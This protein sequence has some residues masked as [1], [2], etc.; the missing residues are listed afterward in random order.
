MVP[1]VTSWAMPRPATIRISVATIGWMRRIETR[2]PFHRPQTSPMP[3]AKRTA[4]GAECPAWTLAAATAPQIAMIAPTE[5]S[6]PRV[7]M[8]SVMPMASSATGAPRFR[9]SIGLP[10]RRPLAISTEKKLGNVTPITTRMIPR[11]ASCGRMR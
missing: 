8:T 6:M 10:N 9:M 1:L 7:A 2:K 3:S 5:R 4:T 11:V